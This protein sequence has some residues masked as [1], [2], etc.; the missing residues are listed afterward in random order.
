MQRIKKVLIGLNNTPLDQELI[1]YA[2]LMVNVTGAEEL[3]F[4]HS[5]DFHL[6]H[7]I[8]REFPQ[9]EEEALSERK[10]EL[11]KLVEQHFHP[12]REIKFS[13]EVRKSSN[14]LKGFIHIIGERNIDLV[15]IGRK[16]NKS[17]SGVFIQ[18][19][20]R[21]APSQLLIVPEGTIIKIQ[22][23]SPIT[24]LLVPVDF[25][26]Y[27]VLAL[28][29]AIRIARLNK[30]DKVEIVCQHVYTVPSGYHYTGKTHEEFADVMKQNA[31]AEYKTFIEPIDTKGINISLV[32]SEDIN[33]D[34]TTDIRDLAKE[35]NADGIVIGSKGHTATAALFL[36][37]V[38]EKL[39]RNTTQFTLLVVR[40]KGDYESIIDHLKKL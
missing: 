8:K 11:T 1:E 12:D 2:G 13:V 31:I 40:K 23:G 29:R 35:I 15:I 22:K 34:K 7:Q 27:S 18:R 4:V 5:L 14:V 37:S 10:E 9:L 38:A 20:A 33:E 30:K 39:I 16:A 6:P 26:E 24:K 36:G 3:F 28:E 25:S 17:K 19:L 32:V 21:R